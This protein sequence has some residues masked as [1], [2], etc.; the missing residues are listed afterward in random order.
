MLPPRK[1]GVDPVDSK[2]KEIVCRSSCRLHS[3]GACATDKATAFFLGF[4]RTTRG[5]SGCFEEQTLEKRRN[6]RSGRLKET[7]VSSWRF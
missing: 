5:F 4:S 3:W 1:L 2:A 6:H 7:F